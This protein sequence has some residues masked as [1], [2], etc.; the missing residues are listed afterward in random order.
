MN[1][2]P[3]YG[4]GI[5][6]PDPIRGVV[7][8]NCRNLHVRAELAASTPDVVTDWYDRADAG[9]EWAEALRLPESS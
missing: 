6:P 9:T 2:S 5:L 7:L 8:Y 1:W 3:P 4:L